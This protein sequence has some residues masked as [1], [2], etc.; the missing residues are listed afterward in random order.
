M[1]A[2]AVIFV[3]VL[4]LV[5]PVGAQIPDILEVV[6]IGAINEGAAAQLITS[7]EAIQ[8]NP[9]A[10]AILLMIDS[11]GG[12]VLATKTMYDTISK[13]RLPVTAWCDN[14]CASGGLYVAMAPNIKWVGARDI[15]ITGSMGV[16]AQNIRFSRLLEWAKVDLEVYRSGPLKD[17]GNPMRGS[18]E[19]E[20]AYL[21]ALVDTLAQQFYG[22]VR[23]A[24]PKME[25]GDFQRLKD[26]R[27]ILGN[28][29]KRIGLIDAVASKDEAV[30]K[31]KE[32]SGSSSIYTRDELK[33]MA[34][35]AE[36]PRSY[37]YE[38]VPSPFEQSLQLLHEVLAGEQV[39]FLYLMPYRF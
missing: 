22:D 32:L 31:A 8:L 7:L 11:P 6:E 18:T 3:M 4:A 28:E 39:R 37:R 26:A 16:V 13:I 14:R 30:K 25:E 35:A 21:Q 29:A 2:C 10:K 19:A 27:I 23:K 15:T 5:G 20:R 33:K 17:A 34:K 12:G 24:R 36:E 1:K 38:S 9:R